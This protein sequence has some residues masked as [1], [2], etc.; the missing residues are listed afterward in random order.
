MVL[1]NSQQPTLINREQAEKVA[2]ELL[3]KLDPERFPEVLAMSRESAV[4][5]LVN[6]SRVGQEQYGQEYIP[7][8]L[9]TLESDL[10][11]QANRQEPYV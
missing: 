5:Y 7:T 1:L 4:M 10:N 2:A 8:S 11:S 6:M 3:D 9:L